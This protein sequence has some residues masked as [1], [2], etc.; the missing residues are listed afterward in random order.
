MN[1][2]HEILSTDMVLKFKIQ[3]IDVY[4]SFDLLVH[5]FYRALFFSNTLNLMT[6][7]KFNPTSSIN[8]YLSSQLSGLKT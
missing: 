6:Q 5:S 1:I 3:N 8:M 4:S 2:I 7:L